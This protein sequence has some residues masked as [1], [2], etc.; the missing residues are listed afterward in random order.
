MNR[1]PTLVIFHA[2]CSDGMAS[3]WVARKLHPE[4]EFKPMHYG[5]ALDFETTA[6][7][8]VLVLDFS[9]DRR[10]LSNL[11]ACAASLLVIDHHKTAAENLAGLPFCVFDMA[12]SGAGLTWDTL[13]PEQKRPHLIDYIEDRDLWRHSLP[14][15]KEIGAALQELPIGLPGEPLDFAAWDRAAIMTPEILS[16]RGECHLHTAERLA[17]QIA[18]HAQP[19]TL[20]GH[21]C[22]VATSAVLLS[23]VGERLAI[24]NPPMGV[25]VYQRADGKWSYS[26]R[27]RSDFDVSAV[28]RQFG[29]GGHKQAAGFLTDRPVHEFF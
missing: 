23:E 27:S 21:A 17:A 9:F 15:S 18:R 29:G 1:R 11:Y 4:A 14:C 5:D 2:L 20:A 19:A 28:A 26:L 6:N 7:R 24:E 8:D 22:K 16:E 25:T 12:R 3:A 13:I 10:I